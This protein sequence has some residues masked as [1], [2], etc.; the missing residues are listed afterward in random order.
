VSLLTN[1]LLDVEGQ[2]RRAE[3]VIDASGVVARIEADISAIK[4]KAGRPGE[5]SVRTLM[6]PL[7]VLGSNGR[8]HLIRVVR[9]AEM[10]S[11]ATKK[12][13]GINRAGGI[14]RRQVE[15]LFHN[16][17]TAME[18]V[19][20]NDS[21]SK[22]S[23]L[24]SLGD[25]LLVASAHRDAQGVSSV[26]IES[27]GTVHYRE[28]LQAD[29]T[30]KR[31][32]RGSDPDASWRARSKQS[33][34]KPYYGYAATVAVSVPEVGGGNVP[35]A[36]LALRYRPADY[37]TIEP[38]RDIVSAIATRVGS[39]GDVLLDR[40][41][42][43]SIDGSDMI[44]PVRALGGEPVFDLR[45]EQRGARGTVNGAIILDGHPFSPGTP[46]ALHNL[47]ELPV[48]ATLDEK[49]AYQDKMKARAIARPAAPGRWRARPQLAQ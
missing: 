45:A 17:T 10:L 13:L 27:W 46:A 23:E 35:M 37:N 8:M 4:K 2:V 12:R 3:K 48:Q 32:K 6:V 39:L 28:E 9:L 20:L 33:W 7:L 30:T 29:G 21:K 34:K 15:R 40:D 5:L 22:W 43:K 44:M 18:S 16:I 26:A 42:T 47:G 41:Y 31:V 38:A 36:A 49:I 24:D 14:T 11:P 19:S 1:E 25:A